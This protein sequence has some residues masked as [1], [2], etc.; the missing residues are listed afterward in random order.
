MTLPGNTTLL[1]KDDDGKPIPTSVQDLKHLI[2]FLREQL[3]E[4]YAS[5]NLALIMSELFKYINPLAIGALEQSF[6]L[7]R[8]ITKKAL[9]THKNPLDEDQIG[10]IVEILSGQYF[11]HSFPISRADVE[12]D[13]KLPLTKAEGG[14]SEKIKALD[15]YYDLQFQKRGP[16]S[17][18]SAEP[19]GSVAAFL[20]TT[21]D[22][23][24]L[25][26]AYNAKGE[27]LGDVW[28]RLV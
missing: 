3:G 9:K 14:L 7:S 22:A 18:N 1:P 5:Q 24:I 4:S 26:D 25:V 15:N 20:H 23:F 12:N 13:L 2:E 16:L 8:L 21:Q 19:I 10:K 11:S 6:H 28:L 27:R 17:P